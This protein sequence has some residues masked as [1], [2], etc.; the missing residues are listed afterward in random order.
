MLDI[1]FVRENL[2]FVKQVMKN[3]GYVVYEEKEIRAV[4]DEKPEGALDFH[5]FIELEEERRN[6]LKEAEDLRNKEIWFLKR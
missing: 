5:A 4:N 2:E 6:I 3:R 1:K